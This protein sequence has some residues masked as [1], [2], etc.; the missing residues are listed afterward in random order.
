MLFKEVL[1]AF[2][3]QKRR[4]VLKRP[5]A[6]ELDTSARRG[7]GHAPTQLEH[8]PVNLRKL[9]QASEVADNEGI[10][11]GKKHCSRVKLERKGLSIGIELTRLE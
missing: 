6:R 2:L 7:T 9:T 3:S 10:N 4:L 1:F 5:R 11:P 8:V